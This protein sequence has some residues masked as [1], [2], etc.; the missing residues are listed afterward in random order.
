[1]RILLLLLLTVSPM[2][3]AQVTPRRSTGGRLA[4][5]LTALLDEPPFDRATWGVHVV[6]ERGRALFSRSADRWFVPASNAKLIVTAAAMALLPPDYRIRTSLYVHG[7]LRDGVLEGDLVIYGR[8]DPSFSTRCYGV[9]TLAAGACD[10]AS[11]R[12]AALADSVRARGVRRITGRV[13]GDGSYFEPAMQHPQWG[14]FDALWYYGAPV[15][16]LAFNDNSIDFTITPAATADAPPHIAGAPAGALWTLENR[17]RTGPPG[18]RSSITDGFFRHPGT[19]NYWAEGIAAQGRRPWTESVAVP[20]PNLFL[21]RVLAAALRERGI[22][23]EGGSASTTDS[24]AHR[25]ARCCSPLV[26]VAGR[27]LADLLFP[28]LNSSQNLFAEMLLKVLGREIGG[29]GSWDAGLA[30]ER[31]FLIDSVGIDSTAF[32]LDDGSG[33]SASNLVTPAAFVQLLG[34]V[35]RHPRGGPFLAALPRSGRRGSL[36]H[37]FT[38]TPLEGRVVAKTGSIARVHTLS[39]F[40]ER[41]DGRRLTFSVMANAHAIGNRAMLDRI[42]AIVA[43]LAR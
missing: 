7:T 2:L 30:V 17:A 14:L 25:A 34:Y 20:D 18:S 31:R 6:D 28:I 41:P 5:R 13:V 4:Q 8:G 38:G 29:A 36:R 40:V 3:S 23:I 43:Q 35:A 37:R 32:S 9:D 39:G 26:E 27:P 10:S 21:A 11:T 16:A 24:L 19:W 1:M 12:V 22:A 15:T 42:D 33:L